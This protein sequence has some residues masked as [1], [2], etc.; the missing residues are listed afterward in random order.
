MQSETLF[1]NL[2]FGSSLEDAFAYAEMTW[3]VT[4]DLDDA[5]Q[6]HQAEL[7]RICLLSV[8]DGSKL[9]IA[10]K[11]N[12]P[13]QRAWEEIMAFLTELPLHPIKAINDHP[14]VVVA[15]FIVPS[16]LSIAALVI[17]TVGS[18]VPTALSHLHYF[19]I[20]FDRQEFTEPTPS[21]AGTT[22]SDSADSTAP[23]GETSATTGEKTEEEKKND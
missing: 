16:L 3:K 5:L 9:T 7:V 18:P 23:E 17:C 1:D 12:K 19:L 6:A 13:F 10:R 14:G 11:A 4:N 22:S 21:Q 20:I 2:Y 15:S 8:M